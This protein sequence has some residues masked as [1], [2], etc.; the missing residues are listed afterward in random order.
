MVDLAVQ[1]P[2]A[3]DRAIR[4]ALIT[5]SDLQSIGAVGRPVTFWIHVGP[6][7]WRSNA[8]SVANS[9]VARPHS[10]PWTG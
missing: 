3:L 2:N 8:R 5:P 4:T 7:R 10:R 9:S 1:L 6:G